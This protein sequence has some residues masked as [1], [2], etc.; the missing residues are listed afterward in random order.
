MQHFMYADF[1]DMVKA[2]GSKFAEK[3]F[4]DWLDTQLAERRSKYS[5]IVNEKERMAKFNQ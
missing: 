2:P 5:D 1:L 3:D 4:W